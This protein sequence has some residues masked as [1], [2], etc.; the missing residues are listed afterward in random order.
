MFEAKKE[1]A[2]CETS[3]LFIKDQ[4]IDVDDLFLGFPRFCRTFNQSH[5]PSCLETIWLNVG[6]LRDGL[7]EPFKRSQAERE[8]LGGL[9]LK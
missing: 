9:T 1:R 6:C 8:R 4:L 2:L 7:G 3:I 5:E